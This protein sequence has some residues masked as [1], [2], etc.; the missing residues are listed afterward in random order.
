MKKTITLFLIFY[1]SA[2]SAG[3]NHKPIGLSDI[4]FKYNSIE[5]NEILF[6][7]KAPA[8]HYSNHINNHKDYLDFLANLLTENPDIVVQL[9]GHNGEHENEKNL[10]FL[11]ARKVQ[12]ELIKR[13]ISQSR[14]SVIDMKAT[15]PLFPLDSIM[16]QGDLKKKEEMIIKN[17][18]VEIVIEEKK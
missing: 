10:S 18:R 15:S 11:R 2:L 4:F 6:K 14:V 7:E 9:K 1:V 12:T 3:I 16:N 5:F 8:D 17:Q 13:G